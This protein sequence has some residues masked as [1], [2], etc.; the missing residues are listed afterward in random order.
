VAEQPIDTE[1]L[2]RL[3]GHPDLGWLVSRLRQRLEQGRSLDG[4]LVLANALPEQRRALERL[5]GRRAGHGQALSIE[6]SA[7]EAVLVRA[8][9]TPD[10]RSAVEALVGPVGD[11]KAERLDIAQRWAVAYSELDSIVAARPQLEPWLEWVRGTGMLQRLTRA[12]PSAGGDLARHLASVLDRL[13]ASGL[14]LSVLAAQ[15]TGDGHALDPGRPLSLL[16]L[17]AV[18]RL[19]EIPE[20]NEGAEWRRTVWASVGI[21]CGELTNPVLVLN[22]PADSRT[23]TGGALASHRAVGQPAYLTARQL[24]QD[25]PLPGLDGATIYLCEN[26]SVVAEAANRLGAACAPLVCLSGHP[27]AAA[28]VLLRQLL[29]AGAQLRY[30][31]DF[32]WPGIVIANSI[33]QRFHARAWRFDACAYRTAVCSIRNGQLLRGRPVSAAWDPHLSD[34]MQTAGLKIE[35]ERVLVDMLCDLRA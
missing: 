21:L 15:T 7:L 17:R 26:P 2:G 14:P 24:L 22:L 19:G 11:R 8:G 25:Q 27:A 34:A 18:A 3:L 6:L 33:F 31:G 16:A 35:E 1:R 28:T 9:V 29:A 32:D 10:L 13:P 5:M 23:P 30:H 4:P 20:D 12:D